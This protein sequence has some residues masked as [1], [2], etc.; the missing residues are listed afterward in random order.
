MAEPSELQTSDLS[1]SRYLRMKI[2]LD[3]FQLEALEAQII[4]EVSSSREYYIDVGKLHKKIPKVFG[5]FSSDLLQILK[6][7]IQEGY[8]Q[9]YESK[10]DEFCVRTT[11]FGRDFV[12]EAG[13][14]G[15]ESFEEF[16][17]LEEKYSRIE[18]LCSDPQQFKKGEVRNVS[19]PGEGKIRVQIVDILPSD[20][21]YGISADGRTIYGIRLL[22]S[23][24]CPKCHNQIPIDFR[25]V[26]ETCYTSFNAF[27]CV[28]CKFQFM[29]SCSLMTY[30]T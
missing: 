25:Y 8:L 7:L 29:L 4:L 1:K 28:K 6:K 27:Q 9:P 24:E 3:S 18:L 23:A 10:K 5:K 19:G 14:S 11:P 20:E 2:F 12:G 13:R 21:I 16:P 26:T 17:I 15:F 22:G 30:Y